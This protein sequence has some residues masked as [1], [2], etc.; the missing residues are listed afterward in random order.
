MAR[1]AEEMPGVCGVRWKP[2]E[3]RFEKEREVNC[4]ECWGEIKQRTKCVPCILEPHQ[5][6]SP[7]LGQWSVWGGCKL[8]WGERGR[9]G[10]Q[11]STGVEGGG[12]GFCL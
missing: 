10:D 11:N 6:G 12:G 4:V 2:R 9:K 1:G 3:E 8:E 5:R 7:M